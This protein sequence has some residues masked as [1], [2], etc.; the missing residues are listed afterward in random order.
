M[1]SNTRIYHRFEW[2]SVADCRCELCIHYQG[3]K[4]PCPLEVCIV[5]D[6]R[7]EARRREQAASDHT[8]QRKEAA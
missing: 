5:E 8:A 6:I 3:E 7:W 4:R 1:G 2:W